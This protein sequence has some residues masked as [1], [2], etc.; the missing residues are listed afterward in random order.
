MISNV[1]IIFNGLEMT[2][3]DVR[4]ILEQED[5]KHN[6]HFGNIQASSK[7]IEAL[8]HCDEVWTFGDC[9]NIPDY[10]KALELMCDIWRMA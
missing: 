7:S 5:Y 3:S 10:I 1:Y 9:R 4:S 6:F 2:E 8:E